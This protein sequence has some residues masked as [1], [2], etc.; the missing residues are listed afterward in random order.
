MERFVDRRR[1]PF[2]LLAAASVAVCIVVVALPGPL[3]EHLER[4]GPLTNAQAGWAYRSIALIAALQI[5]YGG[6]GVFR[7][8]RVATARAR[9]PRTGSDHAAL[10]ASLARTAAAM[11]ALTLVYGLATIAITGLRGGFWL[12]AM[13]AVAQGAWYYRE[14][15]QI[16]RWEAFQPVPSAPKSAWSA[17]VP[18]HVPALARGMTPIERTPEDDA[19]DR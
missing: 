14:L 4:K 11:I 17:Q 6:F 8:E 13:F 7:V 18:G 2:I 5:A 12:F 10:I 9:D 16:A 15:G 3:L 1:G 19:G